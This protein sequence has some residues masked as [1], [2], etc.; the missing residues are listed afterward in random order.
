MACE[1]KKQSLILGDDRKKP[2]L[3]S[4]FPVHY[5]N[6]PIQL[7]WKVYYQKSKFCV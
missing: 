2:T 5:K 3:E 6:M 1:K 4:T 7:Y